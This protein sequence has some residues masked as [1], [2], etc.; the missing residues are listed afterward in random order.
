MPDDLR[1]LQPLLLD[2]EPKNCR[3]P[4]ERT[5]G[6]G[7]SRRL[8]H[9]SPPQLRTERTAPVD[10]ELESQPVMNLLGDGDGPMPSDYHRD[11]DDDVNQTYRPSDGDGDDEQPPSWRDYRPDDGDDLKQFDGDE[12]PGDDDDDLHH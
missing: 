7:G 11:G 8:P 9:S 2:D 10:A 3:P 5:G 6:D 4:K 12:K 1:P